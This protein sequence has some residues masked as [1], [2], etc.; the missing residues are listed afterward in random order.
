MSA[1]RSA[2]LPATQLAA[3]QY[4]QRWNFAAFPVH[5]PKKGRDG[6]LWC[7]CGIAACNSKAK[8]PLC[9][10]G[11]KDATTDPV[12][13]RELWQRHPAANV[14]YAPPSGIIVLDVDPR[15][16]GDATLA[17][18]EA[19][20]GLPDT[21]RVLTG[22]GG[23][24]LYLRVP[25]NT[26]IS[27][28][29]TGKLGPGIDIKTEGGYVLLPPSVH[30][31]GNKYEWEITA[32]ID[33]VNI[34]DAPQWLIDAISESPDRTNGKHFELPDKICDGTRNDYLFRFARSLHARKA[35]FDEIL[36]ALHPV[37]EARCEPPLD[38]G[39]LVPIAKNATTLGDT[40]AFSSA[41]DADE[42]WQPSEQKPWPVM[43]EA[44]YYGPMGEFVQLVAPHTEADEAA[45]LMQ[46]LTVNGS[47]VGRVRC[48]TPDF[49]DHALNV[50]T[51]VVG[52]SSKARKGSALSHGL[53]FSTLINADFRK[54]NVRSG[55][56]S[57][58]G[59]IYWVRDARYEARE[60]RNKQTGET[61][62]TRKLVDEGVSDKRLMLTESEFSMVLKCCNR[63]GNI[64]SDTLRKA[65][66]SGDLHELVKNSPLAATGAHISLCAHITETELLKHLSDIEAANG[67]G[68]RY[69]FCLA[70]R[71][72]VMAITGQPD[73]EEL[74]ALALRIR[75]NQ[76]AVRKCS[77]IVFSDEAN[78]L[79]ESV[80]PELS[81]EK[82]GMFGHLIAR[83]EAQTCRLA[84]NYAAL[85]GVSKVTPEHLNAALAVWNYSRD[86]VLYL[87]GDKTGNETADKILATLRK[88]PQGAKLTD[89]ADW[90]GRNQPK[91]KLHEALDLLLRH[92]LAR[93][94]QVKSGGKGRPSQLWFAVA[95]EKKQ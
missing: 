14:A 85:D 31:S 4:A 18:L 42:D 60:H 61:V 76:E 49:M 8:H 68:N 57:G 74:R 62:R 5:Y 15:H 94:V 38:G 88:T 40:R 43:A 95:T 27:N 77:E 13:I 89:I 78:E 75:Q 45:L 66:D 7:S 54:H 25:A 26:N 80:Y 37:N 47:M 28:N 59:L 81:Q 33:E 34:A 91:E 35:T 24:H 87:F 72:K 29:N 55:L 16:G 12:R 71:S 6:A 20:H 46:E 93:F 73:Q 17:E 53:R 92:R 21:P 22:G 36:A 70:R 3:F 32:R 64:L 86:S 65:W 83:S 58:E 67:F 50:F 11:V 51:L 48:K 79:W 82:F 56:N 44:A 41:S 84:F 63:E 1:A 30:I 10:H 23:L 90:T 19:T 52:D 39:E 69:L 9:D 2:Q